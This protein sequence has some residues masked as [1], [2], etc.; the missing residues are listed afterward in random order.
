M[1]QNYKFLVSNLAN[2]H[3]LFLEHCLGI[4]IELMRINGKNWK[5]DD[6]DNIWEKVLPIQGHE[7]VIIRGKAESLINLMLESGRFGSKGKW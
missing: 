4:F 3:E 7:D 5:Q 6:I 2:N 1:N